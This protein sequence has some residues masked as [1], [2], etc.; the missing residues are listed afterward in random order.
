MEFATTRM[1]FLGK[2]QQWE[3][4]CIMALTY[5]IRSDATLQKVDNYKH[6][7]LRSLDYSLGT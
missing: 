6:P 4:G 1:A 7:G 5:T 2:S 3:N